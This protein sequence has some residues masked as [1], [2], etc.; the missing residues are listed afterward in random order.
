MPSG[1]SDSVE[2]LQG[3][4]DLIVLRALHTMGPLHAYGLAARLEQVA[5]HRFVLNQGTLYPALVR[6][7]QRGFI[8]GTWQ[9]TESNRDAKFYR[10]TKPG[11]RAVA[12]QTQRWRRLAGLVEKLLLDES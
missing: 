5:D 2:L 1:H 12:R 10:I 3:A 9:K 11:I 6:L 4:L 7:E 8:K